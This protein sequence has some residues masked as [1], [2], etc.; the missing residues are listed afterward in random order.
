M[1]MEFRQSAYV[2]PAHQPVAGCLKVSGFLSGGGRD[3]GYSDPER[4]CL[5]NWS[6]Q[7]PSG[8]LDS[9]RIFRHLFFLQTRS[10]R[11]LGCIAASISL[12]PPFTCQQ[13]IR[14]CTSQ[15]VRREPFMNFLCM[16]YLA[17][18]GEVLLAKS[19]TLFT[20]TS[21]GTWICS[22]S[23]RISKI[24]LSSCSLR[25]LPVTAEQCFRSDSLAAIQQTRNV[26]LFIL[27]FGLLFV[28]LFILLV[29]LVFVMLFVLLFGVRFDCNTRSTY[30][31]SD[32]YS[33]STRC[34]WCSNCSSLHSSPHR[35]WWPCDWSRC[36]SSSTDGE[37]AIED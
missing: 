26:L 34:D 12:R 21:M 13:P 17:N 36:D 32:C 11:A 29:G 25:V 19:A 22:A 1:R 35:D 18:C 5:V 9:V 16:R 20:F 2:W 24:C 33:A 4:N 10:D 3:D 37:A 30:S 31:C 8:L 6:H 15:L 14:F 23:S 28:L 27:L 7:R